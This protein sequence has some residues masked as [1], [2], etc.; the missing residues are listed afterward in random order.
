VPISWLVGANS[1]HYKANKLEMDVYN[2]IS[3]GGL[4]YKLLVQAT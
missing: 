2:E 4:Q 1:T 3:Y